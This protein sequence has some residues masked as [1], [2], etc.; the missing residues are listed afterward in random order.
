MRS[1]TESKAEVERRL[2]EFDF[3]LGEWDL[4][5][6]GGGE[7]TNS[8]YHDFDGRVIVES[9]D[10][11]PSLD[12]QGMSVST[13]DVDAGC[14]KQTWVDNRGF[15]AHAVGELVDGEMDLRFHRVDDGQLALFRMRWFDIRPGSLRWSYGRS[16]DRGASWETL[17][18]ISYTRV[19]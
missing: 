5:W 9:F 1:A 6:E 2:R 18:E 4:T 3:W 7:G 17:W 12:L 13:Y 8:V 10:A 15:H 16:Y 11:R 19:L 14:W